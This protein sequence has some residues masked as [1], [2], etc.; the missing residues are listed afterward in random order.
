MKKEGK[1][2]TNQDGRAGT[3]Y[4]VATPIGNLEDITL[5]AL[6]ILKEVSL[7]AA[8]NIDH[9]RRL[10]SHYGIRTRLL[11]YNQHNSASKG[12]KLLEILD[13]GDDIAIVTNAGTPTVSDPGSELVAIAHEHGIRVSPIPGPSA[14]ITALS[15][16]G[17]KVDRF[18]F[19]G[20]LPNRG[21]KRRKYI[22]GLLNERRTMIL[23]EAPHRVVELLNDLR[24]ILGDRRAAVLR[25]LTKVYE[26]IKRGSISEILEDMD[27]EMVKGEFTIIISGSERDDEGPDDALKDRIG[28]LLKD[29]TMGAREIATRLSGEPGMNYRAVYRECLNMMKDIIT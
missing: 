25:E 29:K 13:K 16:S 18:V 4:V 26:E 22:R 1:D 10:C 17:L 8:E 20:F 23:Y 12:P 9:T 5:R 2:K 6:K 28:E 7:I 15:V 14:V 24:D 19:I 11:S 21:G 27:P 3:L